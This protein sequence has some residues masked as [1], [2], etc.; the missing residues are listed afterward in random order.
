MKKTRNKICLI[1]LLIFGF[2]LLQGCYTGAPK[3][4]VWTDDKTAAYQLEEVKSVN[5]FAPT[6]QFQRAFSCDVKE[7]PVKSNEYGSGYTKH[8]AINCD[9][10]MTK[11]QGWNKDLGTP[12]GPTIM[13]TGTGIGGAAIIADG[14]KSQPADNVNINNKNSQKQGQLQGQSQ[15]SFNSNRNYNSNKNSNCNGFFC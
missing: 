12:T 7:T 9:K 5:L 14:L 2:A 15:K 4:I 13:R 3:H 10:P 8:E 6:Y 1:T 11:A